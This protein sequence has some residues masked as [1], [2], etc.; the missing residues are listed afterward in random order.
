[1]LR[2]VDVPHG[3]G[4][5]STTS[6]SICDP[7][8][9]PALNLLVILISYEPADEAHISWIKGTVNAYPTFLILSISGLS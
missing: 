6:R 2:F 1:M 7:F 4:V 9:L 8:V 3:K 5:V